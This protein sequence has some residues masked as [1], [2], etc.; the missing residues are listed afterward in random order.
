MCGCWLRSPSLPSR[1]PLPSLCSPPAAIRI[2]IHPTPVRSAAL[3][4]SHL[5]SAV[6]SLS[7]SLLL[8][9]SLAP[10]ACRCPVS[11]GRRR[12]RRRCALL[13][14]P[15]RSEGQ[16]EG[17]ARPGQ[18]H[19]GGEADAPTETGSV[20]R[21]KGEAAGAQRAAATVLIT[22]HWQRRDRRAD[23]GGEGS[24]PRPLGQQR[25][26]SAVRS[27]LLFASLRPSV[28]SACP[29]MTVP[30]F[31]AP[32]P[33]TRRRCA[34]TRRRCRS[35]KSSRQRSERRGQGD[36]G[37]EIAG[38]SQWQGDRHRGEGS[39]ASA[40]DD[41][42]DGC[43]CQHWTKTEQSRTTQALLHCLR[44]RSSPL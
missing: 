42:R 17:S 30:D 22:G 7:L 12:R 18:G 6:L 27:S 8:L 36:S 29:S 40:M 15:L 3:A 37:S 16:G 24:W 43:C 26:C 31:P 1:L 34:S 23:G 28:P 11:T 39:S 25:D 4:S 35:S 20:E 13:P 9:R 44:I 19:G 14:P 32:Q 5:I 10:S 41:R 21:A 33:R 2:R 38:P